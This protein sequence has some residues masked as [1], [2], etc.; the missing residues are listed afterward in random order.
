MTDL[1]KLRETKMEVD[2]VIDHQCDHSNGCGYC[3]AILSGVVNSERSYGA[4]C[5][6]RNAKNASISALDAEVSRLQ[7]LL[8][9]AHAELQ[10]LR[11]DLGVFPD[12]TEKQV[13]SLRRDG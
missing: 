10:Q 8:D 11:Q 7:S 1:T 2:Y 5:E 4:L 6:F 9:E 12:G 3:A 13:I